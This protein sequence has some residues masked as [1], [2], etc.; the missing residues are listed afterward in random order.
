MVKIRP[1]AGKALVLDYCRRCGGVWFDAGEVA[2]LRAASPRALWAHVALSPEAFRMKCH[3]CLASFRRNEPACPACGRA[4][5]LQCPADGAALRR[6]TQEG[7][8]VDACPTCR[9]VWFDNVELAEIWNRTLSSVAR[10]RPGLVQ[11][12][13]VD[14][15]HF[16]LYSMIWAPDVTLLAG[17]AAVGAAGALAPVAE[18][19]GAAAGAAVE[20]TGELA[21]GV[22]SAIA[23]LVSGI[24][25]SLG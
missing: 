7:L 8:T 19:A 20:A 11:P 1:E 21:S 15:D 6:L 22:F 18:A 13:T 2:A 25:D 4:N 23:D 17:Q 16:L 14:A 9:G 3:R 24:F 10:R 5:I 12:A